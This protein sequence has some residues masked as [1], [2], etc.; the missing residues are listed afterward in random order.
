M[1]HK[2]RFVIGLLVFLLMAVNWAFSYFASNPRPGSYDGWTARRNL[3]GG[4]VV[5][6]V[7]P[8]GPAS[9]LQ[10]GDELLRIN[11]VPVNAGNPNILNFNTTV[12]PGTRYPVQLRRNGQLLELT[13]QT[14]PYGERPWTFN[15]VWM[16]LVYLLFLLTGG[17][18]FLLRRDDRQAWLLALMLWTMTGLTG[19]SPSS[20]LPNWL[21]Y[22]L[23]LARLTALW[24]MP[25]MLHFFMTFPE[26][27]AL[28]RRFPQLVRWLYAAFLLFLL[29]PLGLS[30]L[31]PSLVGT[32]LNAWLRT[33]QFFTLGKV[34]LIAYVVGGLLALLANYR[35]AD[36]MARR[37]LRVILVGSGLGM[38]NLLLMPLGEWL[39][40]QSS[41]P[42]VWS[43][44]D[45]ALMFTLPMVPL[46]F[47]YAI[48][49][50][51]VIPVSLIIRRG[52][53]YVLV[54][55]GAILI[56]ASLAIVL[57][58]LAIR[59]FSPTWNWWLSAVSAIVGIAAWKLEDHLH[60]RFV[61]P[62][63]DRRFFRQA[64]NAQQIM[65]EL[66]DS[67]RSTTNRAELLELGATKIQ[68]ALQTEHVTILLPDETT[69]QFTSVY[70]RS[71]NG[72]APDIRLAHDAEAVQQLRDS[73]QPLELDGATNPLPAS[74]LVPLKSKDELSGIIALGARRGD[75]PFSNEDKQLLMS[76]GAP[77]SFALEN[78][79]LIERM[80][81]EARRREELEAE[82]EQRAK[83][84]EEARQ[85]QL[86]MLPK[87][88]PQVPDLEIAA[89]MKTATEV[90]GDYYDFHVADD[91]TLTIA[92]GD[93]TGHGLKAGT[94]VTAT[95][96]L[97]NELA[98]EEDLPAMLKRFSHAL[99]KM[100]LRSLFMALTVARIKNN[101][102]T[103]TAAGMPPILIYR[104]SER[105]IEEVFLKAMPLGCLPSYNYQQQQVPL[106]SG[107]V[108][109]LMSDGFPER[110]NPANEMLGYDQAKHT[111][112][113]V[114]HLSS[115]EI[116]TRL[117]QIGDEWG[118]S[119]LADDDV[120]FVVLKIR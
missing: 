48:I 91:G 50:H 97:F 58:V 33:P 68:S 100:N 98:D 109:V 107:D 112:A 40:L 35:A 105:H 10:I 104:A 87:Q 60:R 106:R 56:E 51:K 42:N 84:L 72:N 111:L 94:V 31:P 76:V 37:R 7:D 55:R 82:N 93:A 4:A 44:L 24:F 1:K 59:F 99:K 118:Q 46:S 15:R 3:N 95:K 36:P 9:A 85:L 27:V 74:L 25:L 67:L 26:P 96:S 90:G 80:I 117:V 20:N 70:T 49:R 119:R 120:T 30:M 54:S 62:A 41:F 18:V 38:L 14:V 103:I 11:G 39:G 75:L 32:N 6:S 28:L 53:R 65:T 23:L 66:A 21:F 8:A 116:L 114:A 22:L 113:S 79:R 73:N 71:Y 101:G 83:E 88:V 34:L 81:E 69:Q 78:T 61:A 13:L 92:I 102:L 45:T 5:I 110:F 57:A 64:Y 19:N 2:A 52:I 115:Q 77:M 108:V 29:P 47:A 12:P 63:I 43:W 86:S 17:F 89:Y 16:M